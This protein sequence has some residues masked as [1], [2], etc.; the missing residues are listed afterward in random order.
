MLE[1]DI[2]A[3]TGVPNPIATAAVAH[4]MTAADPRFAEAK[5]MDISFGADG[6]KNRAISDQVDTE[7]TK[8]NTA[9][10][11]AVAART[12]LK[13]SATAAKLDDA[14]KKLAALNAQT[15]A[16]EKAYLAYR[17]IPH[18]ADAHE[19]GDSESEA[20]SKLP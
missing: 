8:L 12:A 5:K 20:F 9:R 17:A 10:A 6:A 2:E 11:D 16:V 1:P 13:A 3:T 19:V 14:K 15:L 7:I 18:E 4:K